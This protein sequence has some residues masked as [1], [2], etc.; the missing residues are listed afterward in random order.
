V[1]SLWRECR[2]LGDLLTD[3]RR[4]FATLATS[5]PLGNAMLVLGFLH[6]ALWVAQSVLLEPVF[7]AA[8]GAAGG[9]GTESPGPGLLWAARGLLVLL[10]PLA[11]GLRAVGFAVLLQAGAALAGRALPWRAL[12]SLAVHLDVVLWVES[13]AVTLLLVVAQPAT[14]EAMRALQLRAGLDLLW[15]PD[16]PG[17]AALLAAANLFSIWWGALLAL[18]LVGMMRLPRRPAGALAG[19]AWAGLVA[20]RFLLDRN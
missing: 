13:A 5:P 20:L 3:P 17:L 7:G 9:M 15:Q 14:E 6:A 2:L 19:A 8:S 10:A 4:G 1:K 16:S 11:M 18:G 12:V